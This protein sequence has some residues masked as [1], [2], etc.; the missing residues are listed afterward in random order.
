MYMLGLQ[1]RA[2]DT[3]QQLEAVQRELASE[4]EHHG[5][6]REGPRPDASRDDVSQPTTPTVA[7]QQ[8]KADHHVCKVGEFVDVAVLSC[9]R[10]GPH[11]H[12]DPRSACMSM[13]SKAL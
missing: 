13:L 1:A 9:A 6:A 8:H 2:A 7:E 3:A 5:G 11:L 12:T 4:E 10:Y